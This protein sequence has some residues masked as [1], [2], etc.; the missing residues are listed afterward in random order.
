M[1]IATAVWAI[2]AIM[3]FILFLS[4]LAMCSEKDDEIKELNKQIY[5]AKTKNHDLYVELINLEKTNIALALQI[6]LHSNKSNKE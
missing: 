5:E 6:K 2:L 1:T 3:A 4:A